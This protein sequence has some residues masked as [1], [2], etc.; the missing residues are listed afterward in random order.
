MTG[1]ATALLLF[2]V[3]SVCTGGQPAVLTADSERGFQ[4]VM[5]M[6]QTGA[7]GRDV[8]NANIGIDGSAV[9][10]ELVRNAPPNQVFV[11]TFTK[12][13]RGASRYFDVEGGEGTVPADVA[14]FARAIDEAFDASPFQC[15]SRDDHGD[16]PASPQ[17]SVA[18]RRD[19]IAV[20]AGIG[21]ALAAGL[22]LL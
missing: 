8:V 19:T 14:R 13:T 15:L 7:F 1:T 6:A 22:L 12:S 17:P 9:H 16:R 3:L 21:A 10:V 18:S 11:L 5:H 2:A 4:R 20:T